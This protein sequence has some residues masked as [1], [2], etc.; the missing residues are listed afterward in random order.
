MVCP[1]PAGMSRSRGCLSCRS[2]GLPRTRGDEP[3]WVC[4]ARFCCVVCP[5]PAGMSPVTTYPRE[6]RRGLPR[7]R[8][9]EPCVFIHR[10]EFSRSA[11]HPRG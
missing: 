11:P 3:C 9:D 4:N 8:G 5:A 2:M 1:A 10:Y 6:V 7:T